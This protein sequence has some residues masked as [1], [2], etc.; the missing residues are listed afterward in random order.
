MNGLNLFRGARVLVTGH[1]GFKGSWLSLWLTHLGAEVHGVSDSVPSV[2]SHFESASL[3]SKTNTQF[4]NITDFISLKRAVQTVRPDFVFHLAAQALVRRSYTRPVE[5]W[6]TNLI[7]TVNMLEVLR[8]LEKPCVAVFITS[9]KCYDNVEWEWGY[10]ETDPLGGGDPYSASKGAAELA[11]KSFARS[12][13]SSDGGIRIGVCR[14][15]NVIGGGDWADDRIIPDCIRAWS[16]GNSVPLRH[17]L[18]TRP[19]QHVLEPLSGYLTLAVALSNSAELHGEA[20]NF[21][22]PAHQN[23]SV[24]ELVSEMALHWKRVQWDDASNQFS[25]Q[26]ESGLLKLNCDKALHYLSWQATWDFETTIRET[27]LWYRHYYEHPD[28]DINKYSLSQ[29]FDYMKFAKKQGLKWAQ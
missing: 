7:G 17:P 13:F 20:F 15:G 5:T 22:P 21:G 1:T 6:Q 26:N 28:K 14:A 9:D 24:G 3:Q 12:F 2:P 16:Q 27:A 29:I 8:T 23:H 10:R 25:G 4:I 19:W 11:I 18:A